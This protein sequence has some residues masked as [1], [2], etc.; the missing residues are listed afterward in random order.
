MSQ[1]YSIEKIDEVYDKVCP[2]M[3]RV[4]YVH[5]KEAAEMA[6]ARGQ[7]YQVVATV[8]NYL[9]STMEEQGKAIKKRAGMWYIIRPNER[10]RSIAMCM[11][12]ALFMFACGKENN[13]RPAIEY[14][15]GLNV[16]RFNDFEKKE[17][18]PTKQVT[19]D[20]VFTKTSING[21][22][23]LILVVK[24]TPGATLVNSRAQLGLGAL[25][26]ANVLPAK[27]WVVVDSNTATEWK[28]KYRLYFDNDQWMEGFIYVN[29]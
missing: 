24:N 12:L 14:K 8:F 26:I 13:P 5:T 7:E 6:G 10:I 22:I 18:R 4:G 20:S 25:T 27:S 29:K 1:K 2:L 11:M 3:N 15:L 9:M 17:V 19:T 28:C 16:F 23:D 21:T